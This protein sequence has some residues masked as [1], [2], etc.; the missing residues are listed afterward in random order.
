MPLFSSDHDLFH[1]PSPAEKLSFVRS[2][3]ETG[4]LNAD[5]ALALLNSIHTELAKPQGN[6]HSL[7]ASYA[8]LMASLN[9]EMPE[10]YQHV[11]ANWQAPQPARVE[12]EEASAEEGLLE[13][14]TGGEVKRTE[15]SDVEEVGQDKAFWETE[16]EAEGSESETEEEQ[17]RS[18]IEEKE[19]GEE[20]EEEK[21]EIEESEKEE[22]DKEEREDEE[23]GDEEHE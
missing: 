13:T 2:L 23:S 3:M 7:Y 16:G 5:A 11:V 1:Q 12:P 15:P 9:H 20:Q 14:E 6:N 22:P 10:V 19:E 17:E 18:E 8:R 21:G 4:A